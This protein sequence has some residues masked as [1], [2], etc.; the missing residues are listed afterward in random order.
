VDPD[1]P[2]SAAL[3]GRQTGLGL[4]VADLDAAHRE[5]AANGVRFPSAPARQPWGGYM[6]L[7][8]DPDG[9]LLY[10]DQLRDA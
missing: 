8:A 10:L 1:D 5:L 9:N 6:A 2:E 3:V 4:G 7:L